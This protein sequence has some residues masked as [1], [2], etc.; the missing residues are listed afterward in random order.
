[1]TLT[2]N[3][4]FA[5]ELKRL[6]AEQ[7]ESLSE[8]LATGTLDLEQYKLMAGKIQGLRMVEQLCDDVKTLMEER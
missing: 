7:V 1:M 2:Y 4:V 6:V 3:K 8:G 5:D